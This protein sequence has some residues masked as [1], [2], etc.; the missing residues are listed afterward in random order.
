MN[1]GQYHHTGVYRKLI[2]PS[3]LAINYRHSALQYIIF[4]NIF[5]NIY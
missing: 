1:K 3:I 5:P 2:F 4:S